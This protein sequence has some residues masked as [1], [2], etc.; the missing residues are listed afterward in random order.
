MSRLAG[1]RGAAE[2]ALMNR[3]QHAT[4]S[5]V[6]SEI[7]LSGERVH[8][9]ILTSRIAVRAALVPLSPGGRGVRGEGDGRLRRRV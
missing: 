6:R 3:D 4:R 5:A 2:C 7:G 9:R 8:L 1:A